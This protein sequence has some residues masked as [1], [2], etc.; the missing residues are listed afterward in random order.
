MLA[1][2][3]IKVLEKNPEKD[4]VIGFQHEKIVWMETEIIVRE[5]TLESQLY[6]EEF[7]LL[8]PKPCEEYFEV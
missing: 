8:I 3:L 5:S 6:D 4:V 1:K 7:I 2:D